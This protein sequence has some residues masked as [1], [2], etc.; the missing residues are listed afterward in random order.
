MAHRHKNH[1][2]KYFKD[3][4]FNKKNVFTVV[5]KIS[6][7]IIYNCNAILNHLSRSYFYSPL[8]YL[9]HKTTAFGHGRLRKENDVEG[10]KVSAE[11]N[12]S[13]V[14]WYTDHMN[15]RTLLLVYCSF[16]MTRKQWIT[17]C[18]E[19]APQQCIFLLH[20]APKPGFLILR[21]SVFVLDQG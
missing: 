6:L 2:T 18:S 17:S 11:K 13:L 21:V 10:C 9:F 8:W 7:Y 19:D 4:L 3:I 12:L 1:T 14:K 20:F 15:C 5:P 16:Y